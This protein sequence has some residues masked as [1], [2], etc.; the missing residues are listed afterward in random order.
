V[1]AVLAL[2]ALAHA[3]APLHPAVAGMYVIDQMEMGGAL[4]LQQSG[5]FRYQFD[6]GAVSESADGDWTF[7]GKTVRLTSNPMPKLSGFIVE[8]DD[9]APAG[10]LYVAVDNP[11]MSWSPLTVELTVEGF[12]Q[13]VMAYAE[14]DGRVKAPEGHRITSVKMLMPV[15]ETGDDAVALGGTAGHRLLFKPVANDIGKAAFHSEPLTV[16]GSSLIMHRYDADIIFRRA[17]P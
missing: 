7:D 4:E 1:I 8:R 10:E 16:K 5:H 2:L 14:D 17:Q 12:R 9:P 6:Y 11:D 13:P 3:P 15:Y